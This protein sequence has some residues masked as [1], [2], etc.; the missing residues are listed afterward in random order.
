MSELHQRLGTGWEATEIG[1]QRVGD[2]A[3]RGVDHQTVVEAETG[4]QLPRTV[5]ELHP[6]NVFGT[7]SG[8]RFGT[9]A[10]ILGAVV[11]VAGFTGVGGRVAAWF[12]ATLLVE[13]VA[14]DCGTDLGDRA[15]LRQGAQLLV[16]PRR[17]QLHDRGHLIQRQLAGL[18]RSQRGRQLVTAA[19][20]SHQPP[21]HRRRQPRLPTH[22]MLRRTD[23]VLGPQRLGEHPPDEADQPAI[24]RMHMPAHVGHLRLDLVNRQL[25]RR[26]TLR[27]GLTCRRCRLALDGTRRRCRRCHRPRCHAV[28]S[29]EGL[30]HSTPGTAWPSNRVGRA[31]V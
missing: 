1:E 8:G 14:T 25:P 2:L 13:G 30:S 16:S 29:D 9:G 4:R 20:R 19:G 10:G 3:Q 21:R 18:E 24:Q 31:E 28:H 11:R 5:V 22:P 23:P 27:F 15:L 12:V 26:P 17:R 6:P 7:R